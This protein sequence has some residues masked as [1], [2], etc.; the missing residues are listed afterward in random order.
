MNETLLEHAFDMIRKPTP[1][2]AL[3]LDRLIRESE[4]A[5]DVEMRE[6]LWR[7][8]EYTRQ[9]IED[10]YNPEPY[11]LETLAQLPEDTLGGAFAR[12]MIK[13]QLDP[14]FYEDVEATNDSLYARQRLYQTHDILHCLLGY[15]TSVLGETGITGFYFGQQDRYHPEG[16]GALMI[17]SVIQQSAVFLNRALTDPEDARLQIRAFIEGYNR[18][19]TAKPFLSCRLE[20][21]WEQPIAEVREQLGIV[22]RAHEGDPAR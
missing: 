7:A 12:H 11:D 19:Y 4:T 13:N 9:A 1:Q 8:S 22:A 20:E 21:M 18:G 17:H 3:D 6:Q 16:G 14:A 10:R 5:E 15:S 2:K